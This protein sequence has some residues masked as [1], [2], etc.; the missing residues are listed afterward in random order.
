VY[1]WF[2]F[3]LDTADGSVVFSGDTSPSRNLI[4]LTKGAYVLV[5]EVID[6]HWIDEFLPKPRNAAPEAKAR[7]L[8]EAHTTVEAVGAVA[9]ASGVKTLV[10][11][12]LAPDGS[13]EARWH[14]EQEGFFAVP[15]LLAKR[16]RKIC[17]LH[18]ICLL[19][20]LC[21][22]VRSRVGGN[23][24][25]LY[26]RHSAGGSATWLAGAEA[27]RA[28]PLLSPNSKRLPSTFQTCITGLLRGE[29]LTKIFRLE[30]QS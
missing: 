9:Q 11:S 4:R 18:I 27:S 6:T 13:S 1:P 5:R 12:H 2:A 24:G 23:A 19:K 28:K 29:S 14:R 21:N 22:C 3:R 10:L 16:G 17:T 7:H 26:D 25:C 20:R 8:L 30:R 15:N